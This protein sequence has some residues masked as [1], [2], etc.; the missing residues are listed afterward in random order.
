M[1]NIEVLTEKIN[2]SRNRRKI[3]NTLMALA[4]KPGIEQVNDAADKRDILFGDIVTLT[5]E[6]ETA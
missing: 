2:K 4:V 5:N 6:A 1:T 3:Y